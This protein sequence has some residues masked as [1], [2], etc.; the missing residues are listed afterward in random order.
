MFYVWDVILEIL[1]LTIFV[2]SEQCFLQLT[3]AIYSCE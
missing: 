1:E 2:K 3:S